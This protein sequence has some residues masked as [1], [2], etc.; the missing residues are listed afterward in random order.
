M[1]HELAIAQAV[2]DIAARHAAA[3][4][5]TKVE[6]KVGHLRQVVPSVLAFNF[7]L[8]AIGTP[9]EGA[10]LVMETVP[11][12][13]RCRACSAETRL[14]EFPFLCGQ[15]AGTD[16]AIIAGDQLTVE[17]LECEEVNHADIVG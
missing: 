13:G 6:L 17:A 7:E 1:M 4:R 14:E 9:V 11:A 12:V 3:R 16:L 15:C 8:V 2:V 10:Q 5:V